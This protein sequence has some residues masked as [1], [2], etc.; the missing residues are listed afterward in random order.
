MNS[1]DSS[2]CV[3]ISKW[4]KGISLETQ[5]RIKRGKKNTSTLCQCPISQDEI[6]D[7]RGKN[8]T[9]TANN[10]SQAISRKYLFLKACS[11]SSHF[12]KTKKRPWGADRQAPKRNAARLQLTAAV[13]SPVARQWFSSEKRESPVTD[14]AQ[15]QSYHQHAAQQ[16]AN[17]H[18]S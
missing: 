1:I 11:I 10:P 13:W 12:R 8:K 16:S 5:L 18:I 4:S 14:G 3:Q 15:I 17:F 9:V 2:A 6:R 7:S